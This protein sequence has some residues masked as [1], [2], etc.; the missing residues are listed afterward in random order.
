[1]REIEERERDLLF[2]KKDFQPAIA[3]LAL[4]NS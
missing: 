4:K 3:I 2:H 1:V